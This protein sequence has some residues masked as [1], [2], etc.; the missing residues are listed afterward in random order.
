MQNLKKN[1]NTYFYLCLEQYFLIKKNL[2][3]IFRLFERSD[4]QRHKISYY[5]FVLVNPSHLVKKPRNVHV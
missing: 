2:K 4:L 5:L 1:Y 3:N